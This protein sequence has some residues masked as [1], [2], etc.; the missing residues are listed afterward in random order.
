MM[1][2]T[3][4]FRKQ[5]RKK[6]V[7]EST[8]PTKKLFLVKDQDL[9]YGENPNQASTLYNWADYKPYL[10]KSEYEDAVELVRLQPVTSKKT[11]D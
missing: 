5:Y 10:F 2:D 9:K 11:H 7:G 4:Q 1:E 6:N 8:L 3:K